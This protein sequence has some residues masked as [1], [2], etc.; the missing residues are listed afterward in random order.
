MV[1]DFG[2]IVVDALMS[3]DFID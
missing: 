2:F 3:S 1:S